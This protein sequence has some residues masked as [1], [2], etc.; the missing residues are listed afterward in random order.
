MN[1]RTGKGPLRPV[2][3]SCQY[4]CQNTDRL[5]MMKNGVTIHIG[6]HFCMGG[7]RPRKFGKRDPKMY[8][9]SWCPRMKAP[10]EL[11]IYGFK[12]TRDWFFHQERCKRMG[13]KSM[14]SGYQYAV[15]KELTTE[16]SAQDFWKGLSTQTAEALLGTKIERYQVI[17]IDDGIKPVFFYYTDKGFQVL[18][19]FEANVARKN[20]M[21]DAPGGSDKD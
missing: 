8:V 15:E 13:D 5:P 3:T 4:H 9:P 21:E 18:S 1:T 16:L 11:R 17:E 7:K 2:C 10:K 6:E 19:F 12:S 14:P 20:K